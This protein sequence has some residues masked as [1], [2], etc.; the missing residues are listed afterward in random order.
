MSHQVDYADLIAQATRAREHAYAPYSHFRVGA[1]LLARSG[2][3][4][5]GCNI[6]NVA[7]ATVCAERTALYK[8]VSE[9]EREFAAIAV[10][11]Q[12]GITPC[13][14]CRQV[15]MEFAPD[16]E[17]I[18]AD[19]AGHQRVTTLRALLPD[20]FTPADL[21]AGSPTANSSE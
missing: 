1:A 18:I 8:A 21:P 17:I 16:L 14:V 7:W 12:T 19:T 13:G 10:V 3:V 6:E 11:T 9:G 20:A 5:T 4:Y 2:R 15:M